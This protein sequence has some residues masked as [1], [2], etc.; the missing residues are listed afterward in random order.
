KEELLQ[1]FEARQDQVDILKF[2]PASGA[3][4][5]MFKAFYQLLDEFDPENESLEDYIDRKNDQSLERFFGRLKD[6][7]FYTEVIKRA[8]EVSPGF[9]E[10]PQDRRD[11]LFVKYM[12]EEDGLDL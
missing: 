4:T 8:T 1:Y 7:P 6:L 10:L 3:A 5:R 2:V 11:Y 12:L 9:A